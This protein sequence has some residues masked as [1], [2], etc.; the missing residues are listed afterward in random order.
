MQKHIIQMTEGKQANRH[1]FEKVSMDSH[2]YGLLSFAE[3]ARGGVMVMCDTEFLSVHLSS[4]YVDVSI[5][6]TGCLLILGLLQH[7]FIL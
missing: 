5:E 6:D 1:A 2:E 4:P 7:S 3:V